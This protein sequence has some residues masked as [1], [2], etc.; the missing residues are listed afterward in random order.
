[1]P[2]GFVVESVVGWRSVGLV[3]WNDR[4][5]SLLCDE[6]DEEEEDED[7]VVHES[8]GE[9]G[10][11]GSVWC[12]CIYDKTSSIIRKLLSKKHANKSLELL[13]QF[14]KIEI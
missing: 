7:P 9:I 10:K 13:L 8:D 2:A 11:S 5:E 1:M 4:R 6:D 3:R 14:S 12:S